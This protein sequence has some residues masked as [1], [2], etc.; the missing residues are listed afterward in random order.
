MTVTQWTL[1]CTLPRADRV[2]LHRL[3][4]G[5]TALTHSYLLPNNPPNCSLCSIRL[6]ISHVIREC[7]SL[8]HLRQL[9]QIPHDV[10]SCFSNPEHIKSILLYFKVLGLYWKL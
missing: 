5:H 3:R 8:H 4:I 2:L 10:P 1:P 9:S 7:P 6:T